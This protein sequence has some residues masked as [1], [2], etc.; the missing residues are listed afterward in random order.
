MRD[1]YVADVGD[2]GKYA[3]LNALA[4]DDLRL[5]VLWCRN[6]EPD[7]TQDGRF[8]EYPELRPCDPHLYDRLVQIV[9][10]KQRTLSKVEVSGILPRNALFYS[11]AIPAPKVPCFSPAARET[12]TMLRAIWFADAF[13]NLSQAE[14]VFLDPDN[15]LAPNR[16]KKHFR[17]SAKYIFEDEVAAW[18]KRGQTVVLYQHQ[19]RRSLNEQV[20]DQHMILAAGKRCVAVSFHRRTARIYYILPAENHEHRLLERLTHFLSGEWGEHFRACN[21]EF[22]S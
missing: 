21:S 5:G 2:F 9:K 6:S 4:G 16:S 20:S 17:R 3:L 13:K 22:P 15:G 8:T 18:L 1:S 11:A 14:L 12:Q 7:A 10:S 19:Q